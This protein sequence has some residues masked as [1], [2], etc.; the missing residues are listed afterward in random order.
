MGELTLGSGVLSLT[1]TVVA[2]AVV[3]TQALVSIATSPEV[4]TVT[5]LTVPA[6]QTWVINDLY[7]IASADYGTSNPV[8]RFVKNQTNIVGQTPPLSAL[9]VTN[10]SRPILT[11]K[12]G[13]EGT[14]QLQVY[15]ITTV[16]N[17]A[18]ADSII[19]YAPL[20]KRI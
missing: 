9:L 10:N 16:L 8:F 15:Y 1:A 6:G 19:A 7:I 18:T 14:S 12:L 20:D 2:N 13:F 17:D 11:P 5:T 4:S 3:N